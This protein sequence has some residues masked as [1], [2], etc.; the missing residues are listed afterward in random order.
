[1]SS[2]E[3][4]WLEAWGWKLVSPEGRVFLKVAA[5]PVPEGACTPG[6]SLWVEKLSGTDQEGTGKLNQAPGR[7]EEA[8]RGTLVRYAGGTSDSQ[9]R[10]IGVVSPLEQTT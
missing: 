10:Y 3:V 9:P 8:S 6:E 5:F 2:E 1:M 4:P 7:F